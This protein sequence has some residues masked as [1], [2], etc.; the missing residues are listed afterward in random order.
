M[1]TGR[2]AKPEPLTLPETLPASV[3]VSPESQSWQPT[4]HDQ[5]HTSQLAASQRSSA[6]GMSERQIADDSDLPIDIAS[7]SASRQS[8]EQLALAV[9]DSSALPQRLACLDFL[10][11]QRSVQSSISDLEGSIA[12]SIVEEH[13]HSMQQETEAQAM[14]IMGNAHE[15]KS[16]T[17]DAACRSSPDQ[18][19]ELASM[20][21]E[22]A[23]PQ[24][25][26]T[27]TAESLPQNADQLPA[28][29]P[30]LHKD[31]FSP[32]TFEEASEEQP[33]SSADREADKESEPAEDAVL[34][35]QDKPKDP[36]K[37]LP[38]LPGLQ[39]I[40]LELPVLNSLD[41]Q[42]SLQGRSLPSASRSEKESAEP[43]SEGE[44]ALSQAKVLRVEAAGSPRS[45]E[46]RQAHVKEAYAVPV[47]MFHA[48][49]A[50]AEIEAIPAA[51]VEE[52]DPKLLLDCPDSHNKVSIEPDRSNEIVCES[53][54]G[55]E[56]DREIQITL[57]EAPAVQEEK[58]AADASETEADSN[59]FSLLTASSAE[60]PSAP[61]L[62]ISES[63]RLLVSGLQVLE[64]E[65][66]KAT[67]CAITEATKAKPREERPAPSALAHEEELA[68]QVQEVTLQPVKHPLQDE[69]LQSSGPSGW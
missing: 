31:S 59:P 12:Q 35:E 34:A 21:A 61:E 5:P 8:E 1:H 41:L 51:A 54:I 45:A 63:S 56:L 11:L 68:S 23:D 38:P 25:E 60:G 24:T 22:E 66:S 42:S 57:P 17:A 49:A 50:S 27:E 33:L 30:A 69:S 7:P 4:A 10:P 52:K 58:I 67:P 6:S 47:S 32:V 48:D 36:Q 65:Q 44:K 16:R 28:S 37:A 20:P 43:A 2:S 18:K 19:A 62:S 53:F 55:K 14:E 39:Q 15:E 9:D 13:L 40:S 46:A 29:Q 26:S 64:A 3:A